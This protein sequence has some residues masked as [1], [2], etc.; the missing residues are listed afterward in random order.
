M[1]G[2]CAAVEAAYAGGVERQDPRGVALA[3]TAAALWG[4]SGAVAASAFDVLS[5]ARVAESRA[6]VAA[7]VLVPLAAATKVLHPSGQLRRLAALGVVLA[8]VNAT[9]YWSIE[10]LGVGP[11][12]T[13]QFLGPLLV[14]VWM[15]TVQGTPISRVAWVAGG[16]A[17]AGIAL[18][19]EAW[20]VGGVDWLG[21]AAGGAAAVFFAAYL[22]L[23]ERLG[24]DLPPVT[25]LAWGFAF[26]SVAWLVVLPPWTVSSGAIQDVWGQVLWIGI[27]GTVVPFLAEMSAL[28]RISAGVVG[29][30]STSEPVI[31]SIAGWVILSQRLAVGQIVGVLAVAVAVGL[32]QRF[33]VAEAEAPYEA[34]R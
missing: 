33:G 22:L 1:R 2:R 21:I 18:V 5:P 17:V 12:V 15:A 14:L 8:V 20:R 11:G 34:A 3:F 27:A 31:A 26:A 30:V 9:Y 6:I 24:H 13:I 16:L 10:R 25:V 32:V 4:V 7:V 23:G 19:T 29:I 28:R